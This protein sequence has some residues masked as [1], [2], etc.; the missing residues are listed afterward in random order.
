MDRIENLKQTLQHYELVLKTQTDASI[1][2]FIQPVI[3]KIK[4]DI[5]DAEL[6][7]LNNT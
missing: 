4:Q 5:M 6:E 1:I 7:F 2:R 3:D